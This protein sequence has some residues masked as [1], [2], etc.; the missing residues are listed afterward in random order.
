V[1]SATMWIGNWYT[2]FHY[3]SLPLRVP[4]QVLSLGNVVGGGCAVFINLS[5]DIRT[6]FALTPVRISVHHAWRPRPPTP[7]P[8]TIW[9][10]RQALLSLIVSLTLSLIRTRVDV[11]IVD[12]PNFGHSFKMVKQMLRSKCSAIFA[13]AQPLFGHHPLLV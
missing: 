1:V 6:L 7:N 12:E 8:D 3:F 13:C 9:I 10:M 11:L 5:H 2:P 4:T